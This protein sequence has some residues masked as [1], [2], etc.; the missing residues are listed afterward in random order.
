MKRPQ[1]HIP[2]IRINHNIWARTDKQ[3]ATAFAEHF[4]SVFQPF[5]FQLSVTEEETVVN[6]LNAPYQMALPMKK[7]C[8]NDAKNVIQ[9]KINPKKASGYDLITGKILK[10][11]TKKGLRAITQIFNAI[12]QTEYFPCQLKVGQIIKIVKPGKNPNYITSYRPFSLL[13][14]L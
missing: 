9:Y 3:K 12:L 1:R 2:P 14:A 10:K 4:A 6:D 8:I 7:I 13:P 5:P 11:K